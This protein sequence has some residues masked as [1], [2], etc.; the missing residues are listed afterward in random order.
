MRPNKPN[1][2]VLLTTSHKVA[3]G[4]LSDFSVGARGLVSAAQRS[5][6][7]LGGSISG[8][9]DDDRIW[10]I[11]CRFT[12][13]AAADAWAR[14]SSNARWGRYMQK[15]SMQIGVTFSNGITP[16][17]QS[18]AQSMSPVYADDDGEYGVA[19]PPKGKRRVVLA[20]FVFVVFFGAVIVANGMAVKMLP[21]VPPLVRILVLCFAMTGL[22][23]WVLPP[24]LGKSGGGDDGGAPAE[25]KPSRKR[26][27]APEINT[28]RTRRRAPEVDR[29]G[30]RVES[31]RDLVPP[32][33]PAPVADPPR[34]GGARRGKQAPRPMPASSTLTTIE[35]VGPPPQSRRR[36]ERRPVAA[37]QAAQRGGGGRGAQQ[38]TQEPVRLRPLNIDATAMMEAPAPPPAAAPL[39]APRGGFFPTSPH[40]ES[41]N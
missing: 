3:Q 9:P 34:G 23:A 16:L 26:S 38:R 6:G 18:T 32:P 10:Q 14:S 20:I 11:V 30:R 15:Y 21:N 8:S 29:R 5:P 1:P 36:A 12:D 19:Q 27:K 25:P 40:K 39:P 17:D 28:P 7:C 41:R 2:P 35:P 4:R 33:A 31:E 37:Q 24:L 22:A 13:E